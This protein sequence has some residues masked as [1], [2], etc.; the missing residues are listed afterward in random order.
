MFFD[1]GA[2]VGDWAK[3]NIHKCNKIISV[4]ASPITFDRLVNNCKDDK[5]VLLNFAV[6]NNNGEDITFYHATNHSE[7]STTNI[8]W[9]TSDTC[10][11]YNQPYTQ[12]TCKTITL[13]KLI[14]MYGMP[15][16]I[17]IDVEGGEYECISSL[18]Q[19]VKMLCFEW[20]SE[21]NNITFKCV[22]YLSKIGFTEYYIQYEDRYTFAPSDTDF[23][24]IS[25]LKSELE[26][27][28]KKLDWGMIWCR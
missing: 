11:F 23:Y 15:D 13:D 14:T 26:H 12:I 7:I 8:D 21:T 22:D 18:S 19:K 27:T 9:L 25:L 6:Y 3:A 1:I 17:K 16:L 20:S 5:I 10:R 2:N 4:E 24:D 28:I